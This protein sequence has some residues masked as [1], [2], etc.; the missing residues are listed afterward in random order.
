M[1]RS[2]ILAILVLPSALLGQLQLTEAEERERALATVRGMGHGGMATSVLVQEH[3]SRSPAE[4]DAFADS[5]VAIAI[6][7]NSDRSSAARRAAVAAR[8]ALGSSA[9]PERGIPY[10][11]AFEALV[12]VYEGTTSHGGTLGL[13]ATLPDQVRAVEF[14]AGVAVS[15]NTTSAITAM[16]YLANDLEAAGFARL[17]RVWDADEVVDPHAKCALA[18]IAEHFEWPPHG[19]TGRSEGVVIECLAR[20]E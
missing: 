9:R 18:G 19:D 16:R 2:L 3:R 12:R 14:L 17:R 7:L 20:P 5:L 15:E 10:P 8:V 6:S 11:R 13:I 4:L 1:I